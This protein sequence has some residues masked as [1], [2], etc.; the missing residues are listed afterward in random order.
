M[1]QIAAAQ[2]VT[3]GVGAYLNASLAKAVGA[4]NARVANAQ[5]RAANRIRAAQNGFEAAKLSL[6]KYTQSVTN[7]RVLE[8]MGDTVAAITMTARREDDALVRGS[9]ENSIRKSEAMGA[10]AAAAAMSGQI[11]SNVDMVNS[12]T[13]LQYARAAKDVQ[14]SR[15][16]QSYDTSTRIARTVQ[17]GVRGMDSSLLFGNFDYSVGAGQEYKGPSAGAAAFFAAAGSALQNADMFVGGSWPTAAGQGFRASTRADVPG[18][19]YSFGAPSLG[20]NR[21]G[22]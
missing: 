11:G 2:A 17:A 5:T 21:G 20:L 6:G 7:Q 1:W 12:A 10:Q 9:F 4:A 13:V 3:A 18:T 22:I 8:A 14:R 15:T 19:G 16:F